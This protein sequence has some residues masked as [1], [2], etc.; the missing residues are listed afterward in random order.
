MKAWALRLWLRLVGK[1][2]EGTFI[3]P[4]APWITAH[5]TLYEWRGTHYITDARTE[6]NPEVQRLHCKW[7]H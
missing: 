6:T 1:K 2:M 3:D 5:V 4:T 7:M